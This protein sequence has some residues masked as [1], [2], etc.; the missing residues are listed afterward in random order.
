[1]GMNDPV[2]LTQVILE[3][4]AEGE[5]IPEPV[6][7]T[8]RLLTLIGGRIGNIDERVAALEEHPVSPETIEQILIEYIEEHPEILTLGLFRDD[9]GDLCEED[10]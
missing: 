4:I 6:T 9:D 10:E 1:M 8:Q 2:N 7:L 5:A 3:A